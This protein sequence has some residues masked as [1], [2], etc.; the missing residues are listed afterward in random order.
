MTL[1]IEL[2]I[3]F[4]YIC[5]MIFIFLFLNSSFLL[6]HVQIGAG[7]AEVVL[8]SLFLKALFMK[9]NYACA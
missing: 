9:S 2:G 5:C 7:S 1:C 8:L 6:L 4:K 3:F